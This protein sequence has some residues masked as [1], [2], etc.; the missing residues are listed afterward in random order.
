M[1]ATVKTF[2]TQSA[3]A[4]A[5][6][7]EK[8]FKSKLSRPEALEQYRRMVF[9]VAEDAINAAYP[10]TKN[11][12][13]ER[14]WKAL[15]KDFY[16][17]G[18]MESPQIWRMPETLVAFVEK[19][20]V[21]LQRKYPFLLELM[22]FEWAEIVVYM[23]PDKKVELPLNGNVENGY[24]VLNP[25]MELLHFHFPVHLKP[26]S[27]I[28]VND[29]SNFFVS[30]HRHADS[31]KVL[32]TNLSPLTAQMIALLLEGVK[33]EFEALVKLSC[34]SLQINYKPDYLPQAMIFLKQCIQN[35]LIFGFTNP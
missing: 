1:S 5:I 25:E 13:D 22:H 32:F 8:A 20:Y 9:H 35:Q 12:L 18:A 7:Q 27:K 16:R 3:F 14:E 29:R 11:L 23:M 33:M 19:N 10:L 30:L 21:Q 26:A 6:R 4:N 2:K 15:V 17:S 31:G 24:I 34:A 28:S